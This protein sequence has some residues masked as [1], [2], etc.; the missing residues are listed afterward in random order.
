MNSPVVE[1][2]VIRPMT[3]ADL[4]QVLAIDQASFA[5]P[6]PA[7]AYRFELFDNPGSQLWVADAQS[8]EGKPAV[9][10]MSVVWLILDE[11]HIATIAVHPDYRGQGIAQQLMCALLA[12]AIRQGCTQATLEVRAGNW[13][14]QRLYNRFRFQLAGVRPRYYRDNN[15]DAWIMTVTDLGPDY[16]VWL[17]SGGW[18]APAG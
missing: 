1:T 6:W 18:K 3:A 11:A 5:L 13:Q 17:E 7:S 15:E 16:L 8:I 14:A 9:I 10:G 2:L 12:G 4:D